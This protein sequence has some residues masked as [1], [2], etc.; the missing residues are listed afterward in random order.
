[1]FFS[2]S[3]TDTPSAQSGRLNCKWPLTL[4]FLAWS[5]GKTGELRNGVL[6]HLYIVEK[7]PKKLNVLYIMLIAGLFPL[8]L[9][10]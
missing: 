1:M 9:G 2:K 6:L 3:L 5:T 7:L 8:L 10:V 4:S